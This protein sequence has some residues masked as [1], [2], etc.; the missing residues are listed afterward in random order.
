MTQAMVAA[1]L[2]LSVCW[3]DHKGA[4]NDTA[5][6]EHFSAGKYTLQKG[7]RGELVL[8]GGQ[9][10]GEGGKCSGKIG[11]Q[12]SVKEEGRCFRWRSSLYR[13]TELRVH[14]MLGDIHAEQVHKHPVYPKDFPFYPEGSRKSL[15]DPKM[16]T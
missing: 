10:E 7:S 13:G 11:S 9:A 8:S 4:D 2:G 5:V 14:L 1:W 12:L 16:W 15:L 6:V 3:R